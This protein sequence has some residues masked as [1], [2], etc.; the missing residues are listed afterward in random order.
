MFDLDIDRGG[1]WPKDSSNLSFHYCSPIVVKIWNMN[2]INHRLTKA[3]CWI[4]WCTTRKIFYLFLWIV[5]QISFRINVSVI[6]VGQFENLTA[7]QLLSRE[8]KKWVW[9]VTGRGSQEAGCKR[10]WEDNRTFDK[11]DKFNKSE[12]S[13]GGGWVTSPMFQQGFTKK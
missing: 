6:V 8:L 7:S 13:A 11:S 3:R 2:R 12:G 5:A 1:D 10:D 9:L 4:N